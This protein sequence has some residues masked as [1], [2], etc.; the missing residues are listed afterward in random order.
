[1]KDKIAII[2]GAGP[3]GL[4]A[5]LELLEKTEIKPIVF[6]KT[7]LVG[8]ISK[9]VNYKG[10]RI[11]IGGHRFFT[12][13]DEVLNWWHRILPPA[14][15]PAWD[16]KILEREIPTIEGGP[17][18]DE[19]DK[20]ML[21]RKR[22]SRI[23]YLKRFFNY[24]VTLNLDTLKKL[25]LMRITKI[26]ASYAKTRLFPIKEEKSLE[27]FFIN[28]FGRELY[29]TFFRD[30]TEKVWGVPCSVIKPKWGAQRVKGLSVS[31]VLTHGLR[32]VFGPMGDVRQKSTETS[33]IEWFFYPK[34]GPGQMWEEVASKIKS[35][36]GEIIMRHKVIG[37][38]LKGK[39]IV[40]AE[41]IDLQTGNKY[42]V[43]G[44]IFFSSMPVRDLISSLGDSVPEEVK[45][46]A[47][48]LQYRS[49]ITMGVLLNKLKLKNETS[50]KTINDLIPD[51]WIYIQE[52]EVRLG[53]IQVYNNW[54]PYL[55]P[56][57]NKVWLGLEYFCNEGDEF[58]NMEDKRFAE[59]AIN[60]LAKIG[61]IDKADV[62][63]Y[64]ILRVSKTY[65]AYF[66]TYDEFH[67]IRDFVDDVENLFLIG[68]NGMHRYNNQDHSM[69]TAMRAVENIKN[70]VKSKENIW[71]VNVE[72]EYHEEKQKS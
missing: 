41:V 57:R 33:L 32:K 7:G 43:K 3:A 66:G 25:G 14:G 45:R 70:G 65:P 59:F 35:L 49:F 31:K 55:L 10:Y 48:G 67:V 34:F 9:T 18:P 11:D 58:W 61:M 39:R 71:A 28:R 23:Y 36:G 53:R 17:D 19:T 8:G 42:T 26:M 38:R 29:E 13:S 68:R 21:I 47:L 12:K 64:V 5:A 62:L 52:K 4:T 22:L 54:S 2:I 15:K 37:L 60:E 46:V 16:D 56:D 30:Y 72:E 24:P 69:L 44:D 40:E 50:I 20:V 63:D 6:E 1:M 27:D 51:N